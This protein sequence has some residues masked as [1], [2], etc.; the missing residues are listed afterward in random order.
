MYSGG[1]EVPMNP[2][3]QPAQQGGGGGEIE[4]IVGF[5][6]SLED[7]ALMDALEMLSDALEPRGIDLEMA[8]TATKQRKASRSQQQEDPQPQGQE[9]PA[10]RGG[11]L[12]PG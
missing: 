2:T 8:T 7:P 3:S 1:P 11:Y 12:K 10:A 6:A 9:E 5:L 4:Q